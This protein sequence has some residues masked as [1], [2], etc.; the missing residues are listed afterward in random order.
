[1]VV[2]PG[3]ESFTWKGA[4]ARAFVLFFSFFL[5]TVWLPSVLF[6]VAPIS[7]APRAVQDIVVS[8][9]WFTALAV[10]M[11]ALRHLQKAQKI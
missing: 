7:G 9:V 2:K 4:Y 6:K 3:H 1:M 8:G 5:M 11:V 10:G